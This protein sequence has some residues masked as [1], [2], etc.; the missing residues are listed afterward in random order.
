M[1]RFIK[2][3]LLLTLVLFSACTNNKIPVVTSSKDSRKVKLFEKVPSDKSGITFNNLLIEDFNFNHIRY[4]VVYQG[5]G[6][7]VGDINND[8][9]M[10]FFITSNMKPDKLYLNKGNMQFEDISEKAGIVFDGKWSTGVTMADVNSDGFIDIYVCKYLLDDPKMRG[11]SLYINNGDMTFTEQGQQY[12]VADQGYSTTANFFDYNKDGYLDLYVGNQPPVSRIQKT[13]QSQQINYSYTDRLFKNNGDGTFTDVTKESGITNY[14]FTLAVTVSDI[15]NDTWPDIYI[16]CDFEE[17]DVYYQN[18]GDGTFTNITNEAM[19][20]ISTFSMGV[21]I[22]DINN[23]GWMDLYVADMVAADNKRLKANMSGMNPEK[24]WALAKA[25]YHHQYM[26]NAFQIN[27]GNGRF[28]EI[29]QMAGVSNTDW[30][31]AT[32]FADY[33]NDGFKDLIVTNGLVKDIK[34]ND[35]RKKRKV[36]MDSLANDMRAKGLKPQL[37]PMQFINLAPSVKLNNYVFRNNGDLTF[38]DMSIDWG[39]EDKTWTHGAAYAD[40]DND[41]DVDVIMNHMND[42]AGL[43]ENQAVDLQLNN[44][45]RI[46]LKGDKLNTQAIGAHAWIY[47][48]DVMQVQE[49]SPVR[50]YFSRNEETLHFGVGAKT[51]VDKVVVRWPDGKGMTLENV[52]VNQVLK[53]DYADA[54]EDVDYPSLDKNPILQAVNSVEEGVDFKHT[55]NEFDDFAREILLPYRMSTLGPSMAVADVNGD[56]LEDFYIGGAALQSGALY[57]QNKSGKFQKSTSNPWAKDSNSED[58]GA[59]F[60]DADGDGDKDLYVSSGGNDFKEG[61]VDLQDRLYIN[62]GKGDFTKSSALPIMLTS[63][64]KADAAD[65]DGDGDLDLFVG[66]RQVPGKYGISANS[67]LLRNEKGKFKN[68]TAEDAPGLVEPGM[69]TDA[70]WTDFD[71]DKD[72]DLIVVGEWMPISFYRNESGKLEDITAELSMQNTNGWWNDISKADYDGD[73]DDDY[74]IG[75]LGLN[76]KYKASEDEP[77]KVYVKDFDNNGTHDVYLAYYDKDGVCYPVRGRQCSSQQLPFVKEEFPNYSTFSVATVD[78][79]LGNRKEGA[80]EKQAKI[81]ESIYLENRGGNLFIIKNLPNR[82]QIAPIFG[83]VSYDWNGDGHLDIL[84]AGNYY[85]REV[86]TTRSDAGTGCLLLGD[87]KGNFKALNGAESGLDTYKD[88]RD[89]QL[90]STGNGSPLI[91]IVNN[92]DQL[93]FYKKAKPP[94]Q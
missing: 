8:G 38:D 13:Q 10:D 67:Y 59:L 73:G 85:E 11:N 24:F 19:R 36:L 40:F 14:N 66:G 45:L 58:V 33:D 60:F 71:G 15:N 76:I 20:H 70:I 3:I 43:Y 1:F 62:N 35:Y 88:V 90:I 39:L 30:S 31:W 57:I 46:K 50:G 37:D 91:V 22:A 54:T 55:E 26:F 28:S 75:N 87:G 48:D 47:Y 89:V 74:I 42:M 92:N 27:N 32:L 29:G 69:V 61:S 64:S 25:G 41:G 72:L 53:L 68:V 6:V 77:F 80:V 63:S 49:L 16:A 51:K 81:F 84:A 34:N 79:V 21:D 65:Y 5:A 23:D 78:E 17:P 2:N 52:D 12:G 9:L 93:E 18:N 94:L 44:F 4:D 83:A 82:A 7:A 56:G 86:E